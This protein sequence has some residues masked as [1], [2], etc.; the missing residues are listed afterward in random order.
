MQQ[1]N[2]MYRVNATRWD[3]AAVIFATIMILVELAALFVHPE[4]SLVFGSAFVS[5]AIFAFG[6]LTGAMFWAMIELLT[7]AR[8]HFTD[9][10][11]RFFG[12]FIIGFFVGGFLA[13]YFQFG[14][15]ILVPAMS[16]NMLAL[17]E[18]L[19]VFFVFVV[20]I[21]DAAWAHNKTFVSSKARIQK[22]SKA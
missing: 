20:L 2:N 8:K 21:I 17:F 13:Y 15:Y 12:A 9:L 5:Q 16:G 18:L 14:Q 19:G 3:L 11:V 4:I 6:F 22:R 10:L 7:P 1:G